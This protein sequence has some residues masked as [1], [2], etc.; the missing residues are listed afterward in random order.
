MLYRFKVGGGASPHLVNSIHSIGEHN[1]SGKIY[2]EQL[3]GCWC[4]A[5]WPFFGAIERKLADG[6]DV[7]VHSGICLPLCLP[8]NDPWD[9]RHGTN[10]FYKR[11]KPEE[12]L[13]YSMS[14]TPGGCFSFG[15]GC[16]G[17]LCKCC[18]DDVR[19]H[20]ARLIPAREMEGCWGCVCWPAF[21]AIEK[22]RADGN[23][24]LWHTGICCPLM[25]PYKDPWDR[26]P[27][28]N[29]F[30]KRN[31]EER[32]EYK[33]PDGCICAGIACTMKFC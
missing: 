12:M 9:R 33:T 18:G 15:P 11:K 8:Y 10:I 29:V 4:C 21:G 1:F 31:G 14:N 22:K 2:A 7:L 5:C 13:D 27:G 3:Q 16:T 19:R 26:L 30:K 20:G 24:T 25:C 17:R 6:P 28:T 32:L 23:D